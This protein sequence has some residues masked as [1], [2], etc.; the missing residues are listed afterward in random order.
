ME[1]EPIKFR[2]KNFETNETL[3]IT[4]HYKLAI[5]FDLIHED[6]VKP[7]RTFHLRAHDY[8]HKHQT[9]AIVERVINFEVILYLLEREIQEILLFMRSVE[10]EIDAFLKEVNQYRYR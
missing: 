10:P 4:I 8:M 5:T 1:L 6:S 3:W 2:I 9:P 7:I